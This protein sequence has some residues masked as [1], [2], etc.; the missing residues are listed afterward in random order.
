MLVL[1]MLRCCIAFAI[2]L[3]WNVLGMD[4]GML[5]LLGHGFGCV[6]STLDVYS[7]YLGKYWIC[8]GKSQPWICEFSTVLGLNVGVSG[9][10]WTWLA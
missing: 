3:C 6:R 9:A 5:E 7:Y 1:G 4:F 2:H 8:I 10:S